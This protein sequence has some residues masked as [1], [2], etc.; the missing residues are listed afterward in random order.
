MSTYPG[1]IDT[2]L[3]VV[4]GTTP[5]DAALVHSSRHNTEGSA[6]VA[7]ET[8]LGT[9][10][11]TVVGVLAGFGS[12]DTA[13]VRGKLHFGTATINLAS[14]PPVTNQFL[15]Y[16]GTSMVGGSATGQQLYEAVVAPS[17]GDYTTLGAALTAGARRIFV[18]AGT[19]DET[20]LSTGTIDS[21][22]YI[23]G[24][25]SEHTVIQ[26]GAAYTA[27]AP[28]KFVNLQFTA[29]TGVLTGILNLAGTSIYV[30]NCVFS[31]QGTAPSLSVNVGAVT[32]S[33]LA[34]TFAS[35]VSS[36][37]VSLIGGEGHLIANNTF[38]GTG[39]TGILVSGAVRS[40]IVGNGTR[41]TIITGINVTSGSR[42]AIVGNNFL[43]SGKG[44]VDSNSALC[45]I[46]GNQI[47]ST[48]D[49]GIE[50]SGTATVI[51]GNYVENT[52]ASQAILAQGPNSVVVGNVVKNNTT[53]SFAL[54]VG[55][56]VNATKFGNSI[57]SGF[58]SGD[59]LFQSAKNVSTATLAAGNVVIY[60]S[61]D[62]DLA[63]VTTTTTAGDK[64]VMGVALGS[65]ATNAN[66]LV[67]RLGYSRTTLKVNGSVPIAEGDYLATHT[68][69]GIAAKAASGDAA[70]AI[71]LGTY[72]TNDSNGTVQGILISPRIL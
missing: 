38:S 30:N 59:T 57:V 67:Q 25:S 13:A 33:V 37:G 63:D 9:T 24:E 68:V 3:N 42:I 1:T 16:D 40:R 47:V 50:S 43:V 31:R 44:V 26:R 60:D 19:Y 27:T 35:G 56:T 14:T 6:I 32:C 66:V 22:F 53:T 51:T 70:F 64:F 65:A 39:S 46:S 29:G 21:S 62:E 69:A 48:T 49:R 12:A 72:S 15:Q 20:A 11:P 28:G 61:S 23:V 10:L 45:V 58:E 36:P 2:T 7:L 17:G 4:S 55:N 41:G 18:R 34:N 52:S 8:R 54:Q 71:S 5:V